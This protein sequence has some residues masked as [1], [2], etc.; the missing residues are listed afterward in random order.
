MDAVVIKQEMKPAASVTEVK[1]NPDRPNLGLL[2]IY[3]SVDRFKI[4]PGPFYRLLGL[5]HLILRLFFF[6]PSNR[7]YCLID[8]CLCA[9]C[10]NVHLQFYPSEM[11]PS[12]G[13]RRRCAHPSARGPMTGPSSERIIRSVAGLTKVNVLTEKLPSMFS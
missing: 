5:F 9:S 11:L 6:P 3:G 7:C 12:A 1:F 2:Q 4:L 10:C 8:L 13:G